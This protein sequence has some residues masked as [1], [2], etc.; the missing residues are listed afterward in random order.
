M[1]RRAELQLRQGGSEEPPHV[2]RETAMKPSP[3]MTAP[4]AAAAL[5]VSRAT[6][7]AYVS[8]G[9]IRS[10]AMPGRP[11]RPRLRPRRRRAA[12]AAQRGAAR[13]RQG[14]GAVAAVGAAGAR[15]VDRADRRPAAV[16]P[17]PRRRRTGAHHDRCRRWRRSSGPAGSTAL[18]AAAAAPVAA[19]ARG[20]IDPS[21][22]F[23]CPG[24]GAAGGWRRPPI[25]RPSTPG[26]RRCV[27]TGW[28]ILR[29]WC[30]PRT[31]RPSARPRIEA[32]AGAGVAASGA[33][34]PTCSA[35]CWCSAPT[36]S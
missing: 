22:P 32:A 4:E 10:Q 34:A 6:L 24:A 36:T 17:R 2:A 15:V 21:A 26:P 1:L 25:R 5:G 20:W 16:L 18:A 28:R 31:G 14:G 27:R 23:V 19:R 9:S 30:R 7:Y 33:P 13:A 12:E 8:R 35:P 3:W 29:R 11:A